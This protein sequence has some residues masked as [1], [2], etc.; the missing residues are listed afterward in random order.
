MK[1]ILTIREKVTRIKIHTQSTI[2]AK[3][4][5]CPRKWY[6]CVCVCG[7]GSSWGIIYFID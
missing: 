3:I 2:Y 7:G 1:N 4:L 6:M 5:M